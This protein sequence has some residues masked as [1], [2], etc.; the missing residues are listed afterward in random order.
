[1]GHFSKKLCCQNNPKMA[2]SGHTDCEQ[3]NNNNNKT[4]CCEGRVL[5]FDIGRK[6]VSEKSIK[7]SQFVV[8]RLLRPFFERWKEHIRVHRTRKSG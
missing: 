8:K 2:Q 3:S 1:M 4:K 5:N 7:I 6:N